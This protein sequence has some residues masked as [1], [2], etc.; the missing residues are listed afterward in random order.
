PILAEPVG[1]E[2]PA[3]SAFHCRRD[4]LA[5]AY[6]CYTGC[7]DQSTRLAFFPGRDSGTIAVVDIPTRQVAR[8]IQVGG[9]LYD[10]DANESAHELYFTLREE[11]AVGIVPESGGVVERVHTGGSGDDP[12]DIA[13]SDT[14]ARFYAA[15]RGT[16]QI[17]PVR[18]PGN[19]LEPAIQVP[20]GLTS[21]SLAVDHSRLR[22][23]AGCQG[24][25]GAG[26]QDQVLAIDI[27]PSS[28]TFHTIVDSFALPANCLPRRMAVNEVTNRVYCVGGESLVIVDIAPRDVRTLYIQPV[29]ENV[30]V[31]PLANVVWVT[32]TCALYQGELNNWFVR[33]DGSTEQ[34]T[35]LWK[36]YWLGPGGIAP[37]YASHSAFFAAG[38]AAARWTGSDWPEFIGLAYQPTQIAIDPVS[39]RLWTGD[40]YVDAVHQVDTGTLQVT[41][42]MT[43]GD[44][45]HNGIAFDH[46]GYVYAACGDRNLRPLLAVLDASTG[47][48]VTSIQ[49][50]HWPEDVVVNPTSLKAY[51]ACPASTCV[52]VIDIDPASPNRRKVIKS[53]QVDPTPGWGNEPYRQAVDPEQ[54][55]VFV[56]TM[57]NIIGPKPSRVVAIDGTTDYIID[58]REL[59]TEASG[60]VGI[61]CIPS[62]K[63]VYVGVDRR[64]GP[65]IPGDTGLDILDGDR[66][67]LSFLETISP[68]QLPYVAYEV[69]AN[70]VTR[71]VYARCEVQ[72]TIAVIDGLSGELLFTA[73]SERYATRLAVDPRTGL[74]YVGAP[75]TSSILVF[76]DEVQHD[77]ASVKKL[78]DGTFVELS[79]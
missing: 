20:D 9:P 73:G 55:L 15:N 11:Q 1:V 17:I 28:A 35:G 30:A 31:D 34:I 7:A 27:N 16:G 74:L 32:R 12:V 51:V 53:I 13:A 8:F 76:R 58:Y 46:A 6:H 4:R 29:T 70:P 44:R 65:G 61:A 56:V 22:L 79:A 63:R 39:A 64:P 24:S 68:V 33:I 3:L 48:E 21:H 43:T 14:T 26:L 59:Y 66:N 62:L 40:T 42:V 78:P 25:P 49:V 72:G 57:G 5:G 19:I 2:P 60:N 52:D 45:A 10:I 75:D 18:R 23:Y 47:A 41:R 36:D 38:T 37:D 54:N 71:R 50:H 67:S 69:C 77:I